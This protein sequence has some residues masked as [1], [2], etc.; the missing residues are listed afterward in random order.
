MD[1]CAGIAE[2]L[3]AELDEAIR[4]QAEFI[5]ASLTPDEF[6]QFKALRE[7]DDKFGEDGRFDS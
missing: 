7:R 4:R 6:E 1:A 5:K 3:I 2:A